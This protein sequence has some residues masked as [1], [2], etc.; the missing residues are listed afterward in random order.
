[1][2]TQCK[3][4]FNPIYTPSA[5]GWGQKI[6]FAEEGHVVYQNTMERSLEQYSSKMFDLMHT[7]GNKF[8]H[9]NCEDKYILIFL[10]GDLTGFGYDRSDTQIGLRCW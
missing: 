3:Q 5:P 7:I 9:R 10:L 6:I 1:M 2:G 4:I 8:R